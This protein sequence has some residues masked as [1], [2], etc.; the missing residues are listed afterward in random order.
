MKRKGLIFAQCGALLILYAVACVSFSQTESAQ[1]IRP[2][3]QL[4]IEGAW[5]L[6]G[7]PENLQPNLLGANPWPSECQWFAYRKDGVFKSLSRITAPCPPL[8]AAS[9]GANPLASPA[10]LPDIS[11]EFEP[12]Q[13]SGEGYIV[14]SRSDKKSYREIWQADI[15]QR[16]FKDGDADFMQGDLILSL[17]DPK[18]N[19]ALWFRH[20]RRIN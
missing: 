1:S 16:D 6:V 8:T 4:D 9:L 2:A 15:V 14:I 12:A 17:V 11:W 13:A 10:N 3:T 5:Q 20:L 19:R 7:F 18:T